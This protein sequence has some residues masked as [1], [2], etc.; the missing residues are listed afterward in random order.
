MALD[1]VV[2]IRKNLLD[3]FTHGS[4]YPLLQMTS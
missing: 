1:G 2:L 3:L 4:K